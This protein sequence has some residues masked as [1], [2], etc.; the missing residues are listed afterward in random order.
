MVQL[1]VTRILVA[2]Y[3]PLFLECSY[4]FRPGRSAHGALAEL[5]KELYRSPTN[6]VVDADIRGFF[7]Q[8]DHRWLVRFLE[9]RIA[10]RNLIRLIARF[11]KAGILEGGVFQASRKGTPQGGI[12]SPVLANIYLHYVLDLWFLKKVKPESSGYCELI[13][14]ADDFII[15]TREERDARMILKLLTARLQEYGLE[16]SSEKTR[17]IELGRYAEERSRRKGKKPDTFDFLGFTHFV[18][19][20]RRGG[21]KVGRRT[22]KGKY[23]SNLKRLNHWVKVN[24]NRLAVDE[25]WKLLGIKLRGYYRY[26]GVSDNYESLARY[27]YQVNRLVFKWMNRRSQRPSFSW[28]SFNRYLEKYP[29]PKPKIYTNLHAYA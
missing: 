25:L 5:N 19:R 23:Q 10:D 21:F 11:L 13:R 17:L 1:L 15:L 4:G 27:S 20:S 6:W 7:D 26:Y 22:A 8:V 28:D 16:L 29:L 12:L 24:R 14:Y 2:I 9:E 18:T 3:E